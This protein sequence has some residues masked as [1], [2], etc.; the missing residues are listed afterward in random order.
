MFRL[1]FI[2]VF[3]IAFYSIGIGA[4]ENDHSI[5]KLNEKK[6]IED[7]IER[8]TQLIWQYNYI[9]ENLSRNMDAR[10]NAYMDTLLQLA[11]TSSWTS[12]MPFY[13]RAKGR[14]HD[15]R[16]DSAEALDYYTKSIEGYKVANGDL[17]ELAF[18][19]VLKGFLL[20]N[21]DLNEKTL[22]VFEEG[23]PYA[24]AAKGKNS[25]CLI[26]DWYGD[27]YFY[28]LDSI[29]DNEKA[30][31]YY[32]QVKEILPQINYKR[33]IADNYA[34]L[35]GVYGRLSKEELAEEYF[36]I[37]DS[38]S[39]AN[40][41]PS[42]RW[43]LYAEKASQLEKQGRHK[44]ANKTYLAAKKFMDLL[45]HIELKS[46][47]EKELWG[48]YKNL[49]DYKNA[50]L[51]YETYVEMENKMATAE[52]EIKYNELQ[53]KYDFVLKQNEIDDLQEK[54]QR[55]LAYFLFGLLSLL[56]LFTIL[57]SR[58]NLQL[59]RSAKHLEEKQKE[60]N[61]ALIKGEKE[62]RKRLASELHDNVNTKLAA[63]KWRLEAV[64][65]EV[66]LKG[67][68]VFKDT[69]DMM[70][71]IYTDVRNISH[72]LVPG[73]LEET[74]LLAAI[75][76]H[77]VRLNTA[78]KTQF[79][80]SHTGVDELGIADMKYPLYN[81]IFELMNNIVKHSNAETANIILKRKKDN[82]EIS[83]LDNGKG[84]NPNGRTAGI[85][86]QNVKSRISALNGQVNINSEEGYGT[87]I[88]IQIPYASERIVITQGQI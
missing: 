79:K 3:S 17:K 88:N 38:I 36:T 54:N 73:K 74:G 51:H 55:L 46:R 10:T 83:I 66:S 28:G 56:S 30:L 65:D 78:G 40:N 52:V 67:K 23:L 8:D 5:K 43:G 59:K 19:Y 4:D 14:Y 84:F 25:L 70:N 47:L 64:S 27:Y 57:V 71:D 18:S 76:D 29:Y 72:N 87:T 82:L 86:F 69:I 60:V 62:E 45:T 7:P 31:D 32:L 21:S 50:L 58:K 80:F 85:G 39:I 33:I 26:L 53:T 41:L 12:A 35:A 68:R 81:V 2:I 1:Y 49:G 37:A 63:I 15:F 6:R 61:F 16:G 13:Y 44:E 20:S 11:E 42:V 34:G 75:S 48:N 77:V 24:R 22:E 9:V